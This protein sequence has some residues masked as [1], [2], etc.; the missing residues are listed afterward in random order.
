MTSMREPL[1]PIADVVEVQRGD[2]LSAIAAR[3]YGEAHQ[4]ERIYIANRETIGRNPDLIQP[5]QRLLIPARPW[6]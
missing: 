3:C 4:W 6:P 5:G 2:T 1:Y